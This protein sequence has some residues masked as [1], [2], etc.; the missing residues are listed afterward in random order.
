MV[1]SY[2]AS[3]RYAVTGL[4]AVINVNK[5]DLGTLNVGDLIVIRATALSPS[6]TWS[7]SGF[8]QFSQ[9][10][11]N[12]ILYRIV[13]GSEGSTFA[14]TRAT[15][16]TG[17]A[18][19]DAVVYQDA[20]TTTPIDGASYV[21]SNGNTVTLPSLTVTN[22]NTVLLQFV[23][24]M[25]VG[26]ATWSP[27]GT[28]TER[29]DATASGTALVGAGGDEV[30]GSGSTGTR[31]W[32]QTAFGD[33]R[34]AMV[35][36]NPTASTPQSGSD[37]ASISISESSDIVAEDAPLVSSDSG[38]ISISENS[39]IRNIGTFL[40]ALENRETARVNVGVFGA[41]VVEGYPAPLDKSIT[42]KLAKKLRRVYP[43]SSAGGWGFMGIPSTQVTANNSSPITW[44]GGTY[45]Q[46]LGFGG[47][48]AVWTTTNAQN[49]VITLTVPEQASSIGILTYRWANGHANGGQ[50]RVN[51]GSWIMFSTANA[52]TEY[53]EIP[54]PGPLSAGTTIEVK[55][56]GGN[57]LNNLFIRGFKHYNGDETTGIH[58]NNYGHYGY[59]V[60]AWLSGTG[61]YPQ[62]SDD[63]AYDDLDIL[64]FSDI[65]GNDAAVFGGNRTPAQFKSDFQ[66]LINEIRGKGYTG[67]IV[68]AALYDFTYGYNTREPWA[69]YVQIN[70][71]IAKENGAMYLDLTQFMPATPNAIYDADNI[72]G[73]AAGDAYEIMADRFLSLITDA[74]YDYASLSISESSSIEVFNAVSASDT[75][76]ISSSESGTVF[77]EVSSSDSSSVSISEA[78]D[79]N[80]IFDTGGT[81]GADSTMLSISEEAEIASS[82][83]TSDSD[84]LS[85]SDSSEL[86]TVVEVED[87]SAV[88]IVESFPVSFATLDTSDSDSISIDDE[89]EGFFEIES[90]DEGSVDVSEDSEIEGEVEASEDVDLSIEDS[91]A[92]EENAEKTA[93]DTTTID[94]TESSDL[95]G[96]RN[97]G[98]AEIPALSISETSDLVVTADSEDE[99]EITIDE[100]VVAY[101]EIESEDSSEIV[102][103]ES[104]FV[105]ED[106]DLPG[107][108]STGLSI[109]ESVDS[110]GVM[111]RDDYAVLAIDEQQES[112]IRVEVEDEFSIEIEE[113]SEQVVS[114]TSSDSGV[115]EL[116]ES[117]STTIDTNVIG[118]ETFSLVVAENAAS[119]GQV[120]ASESCAVNISETTSFV[121]T[122]FVEAEETQQ[123]AISETRFLANPISAS[124]SGS[125]SISESTSRNISV[126]A[127]DHAVIVASEIS[128]FVDDSPNRPYVWYQGAW[129]PGTMKVYID[130]NWRFAV[131]KIYLDGVWT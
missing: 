35:A 116:D 25:A 8:T 93:S 39:H 47:H 4:T 44:S 91:S 100:E 98:G 105:Y 28:A 62:W 34:G 9:S 5:A 82:Q 6:A 97:V 131:K 49:G 27:P 13:D 106:L 75:L 36:I 42:T 89:Y 122:Q 63:I 46:T 48:H 101:R 65:G 37:T 2:K 70:K 83:S 59:T 107:S 110:Q 67:P 111:F 87:E 123:V 7:C 54:V 109:T 66:N 68:I 124:D 51:G 64:V 85:I 50:Y 58:V 108:D 115:F 10:S 38:S 81:P 16:I 127:S 117:V 60:N 94:I 45:N 55:H 128:N 17:T 126:S 53:L 78:V 71:E 61:G 43:T 121:Q 73:N 19:V 32:V 130:G 88:E 22:G 112:I 80:V 15:N 29:W 113:S 84:S 104:S 31:A 69:N 95:G 129:R 86:L 118:S 14:V 24:K 30:V 96:T 56:G 40:T 20:D 1:A 103:D 57:P 90:E 114:I 18:Y 92:I 77:K 26:A 79:I 3:A 23:N 11:G 33:T 76:T 21:N 102:L 12:S 120:S 52:T 99:S 72:H 125:V 41:S 74:Y 119:S